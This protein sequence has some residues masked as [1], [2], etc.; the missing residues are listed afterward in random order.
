[1][2]ICYG[3]RY[4]TSRHS[5]CKRHKLRTRSGEN[6]DAEG[7]VKARPVLSEKGF[8]SILGAGE[9]RRFGE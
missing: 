5:W 3:T 8:S 1:M 9:S 4:L 2:L 6:A 7:A